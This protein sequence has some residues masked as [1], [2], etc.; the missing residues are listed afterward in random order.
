[1][2]KHYVILDVDYQ[3][4]Y[5]RELAWIA[6]ALVGQP[7]LNLTEDHESEYEDLGAT[8]HRKWSGVITDAAFRA[9]VDDWAIDLDRGDGANLGMITEYGLLPAINFDFSGM[10]WNVG[11]MTP[12][13]C[14]TLSIAG[15]YD[16]CE[17][18]S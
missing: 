15:H 14:A 7:D 1:M 2:G 10:D 6:P 16:D 18:C 5:G 13:F 3:H 11:G 12:I 17:E 4:D 8:W 9:L